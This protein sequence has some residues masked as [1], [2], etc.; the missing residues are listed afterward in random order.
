MLARTSKQPPDAMAFFGTLRLPAKPAPLVEAEAALRRAAADR[1]Q[2]QA[3]HEEAGRL[4]RSQQPGKVPAITHADH[5]QIGRELADAMAAEDTAA[6][7][8]ESARAAYL[9]EATEALAGPLAQY[10][11]AVAD[12]V[13]VLAELLAMG[14]V[15]HAE[16]TA[17]RIRLD[18]GLP[19]VCGYMAKHLAGVR[20]TMNRA[21]ATRR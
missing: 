17:A 11:R 10:E 13:E 2:A 14:S 8:A 9:A 3:R 15:L 7:V 16:A 5:D 6:D 4:L 1:V 18:H 12:Q 20:A 21:T 19:A